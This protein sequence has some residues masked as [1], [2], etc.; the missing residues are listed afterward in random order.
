[1]IYSIDSICC[2]LKFNQLEWNSLSCKR[3]HCNKLY[4][5]KICT[6]QVNRTRKA[7]CMLRVNLRQSSSKV[8]SPVLLFFRRRKKLPILNRIA[9]KLRIAHQHDCDNFHNSNIKILMKGFV[10]LFFWLSAVEKQLMGIRIII[11]KV[12]TEK[13]CSTK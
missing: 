11:R 6:H 13:Y 12:C 1:M 7:A 3:K 2:V 8:F 10:L 5:R 4:L 9:D